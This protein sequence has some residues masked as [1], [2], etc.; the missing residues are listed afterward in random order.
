MSEDDSKS[1]DV[2]RRAYVEISLELLSEVLF[3]NVVEVVGVLPNYY[4][5]QQG[6]TVKIAVQGR[7]LPKLGIDQALPRAV[8][9]I[10]SKTIVSHVEVE[11]E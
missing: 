1:S 9:T 8:A 2:L 4:M 11:V 7:H 5:D 6:K 3:K 10:H